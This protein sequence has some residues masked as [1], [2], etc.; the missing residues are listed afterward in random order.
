MEKNSQTRT[1]VIKHKKLKKRAIILIFLGI[2]LLA[3]IGYGA[4]LY[5]QANSAFD[6]AFNDE[7]RNKSD[8]RAE[9]VNPK[10]DNVSVLIMGVDESDKRSDDGPSRTDSLI[11]ATLN[12]KDHSVKLVSIPRDSYVYIPEIGYENKINHAYAYGGARATIDTVENLFE[13]PVDYYVKLNF[14]AFVDVIDAINGIEFD[15]PYEFTE[16]DSNDKQGAIHLLP[17][18][19]TLNGEEALA[20]ARTRKKDSD[21][22]RG[23]RQTE[24]IKATI[25]KSTSFTS[26]LKADD[27]I[28]AIASNIATDLSFSDLKN[29]IAYGA[30]TG[31]LDI[32]SLTLD[33]YDYKP[34]TVYYWQLDELSLDETKIELKEHLGLAPPALEEAVVDELE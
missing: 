14:H 32:E 31:D 27:V 30:T 11:L 17:G 1:E 16:Q 5:F 7:G 26:I 24:I 12:K 2:L 18:V 34:S 22:E 20:L 23:K 19:Q 9:A 25:K 3:A 29:L 4:Y 10:L 6:D 33:G 21:V 8:L 28:H 15:V 13:I